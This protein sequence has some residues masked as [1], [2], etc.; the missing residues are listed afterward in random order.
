MREQ[1]G[2]K[3]DA[4]RYYR[5]CVDAPEI[6]MLVFKTLAIDRLRRLGVKDGKTPGLDI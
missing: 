1:H 2:H 4:I 5:R 3:D 6:A